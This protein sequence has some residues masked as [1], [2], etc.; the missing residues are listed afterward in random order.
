[1]KTLSL[2][3]SPAF[4]ALALTAGLSTDAS[5][6]RQCVL[7]RAGFTAHVFWYDPHDLN[8]K[9]QSP[10]QAKVEL[11]NAGM[12]AKEQK[13]IMSG[14]ESCVGG[15]RPLLAV[16]TVV[17]GKAA[18]ITTQIAAGALIVAGAGALCVVT[19]GA[20]CEEAIGLAPELIG[21]VALIPN[22]KGAFYADIPQDIGKSKHR[23]IL[24][25]SVWDPTAHWKKM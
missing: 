4:I 24:G 1:M 8:V 22:A 2:F 25:G 11:K 7:N 17:D 23:L 18:K 14:Q 9:L 15:D 13:R 12:N 20:G 3:C 10:K 6:N 16:I 21:V 5:A 19:A